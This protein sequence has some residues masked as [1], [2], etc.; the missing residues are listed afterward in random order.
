MKKVLF[1]GGGGAGSEAMVRLWESRYEVHLADADPESMPPSIFLQRRHT[2]ALAGPAWINSVADLCRKESIDILFPTV[3]EELPLAADLQ[4][5]VQNTLVIV[6]TAA[7]ID[8]MN[9]K[10]QFSDTLGAA[11]IDVPR[12]YTI[13]AVSMIGFPCFAKPRFG[14][15]SRGIQKL[16]NQ[17]EAD[18]YQILSHD[19]PDQLLVQEHLT[20]QEWTV[21]VSANSEGKLRRVVPVRVDKKKGITIRAETAHHQGITDLCHR[22]QE[23]F[24][25]SGCYNVQLMETKDG[26][27]VVFEINPRVST[28]LCL[29]VASGA[30][31]IAEFSDTTG[32]DKLLPFSGGVRL[33]RNWYN[34]ITRGT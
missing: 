22:I 6:P 25:T 9:D 5:A 1:T 31:P 11:G 3:D 27:L 28:T 17:R 8:R 10:L 19:T 15:G 20:G 33:Q 12:T 7:F 21:Y 2:I 18:A 26:R 16:Q 14:R 29:A 34:H 23:G 24:K 30:D 32:T 4:K 13:D